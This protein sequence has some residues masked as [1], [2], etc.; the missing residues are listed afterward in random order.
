[1]QRCK[2]PGGRRVPRGAVAVLALALS[3]LAGAPAQALAAAG[4]AFAR[5]VAK[6]DPALDRSV[7]LTVTGALTFTYGDAAVAVPPG[8]SNYT[9][10]GQ[11]RPQTNIRSARVRA[12][13]HRP[14]LQ[15]PAVSI[16]TKGEERLDERTR[17]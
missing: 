17:G 2:S 8:N 3:A 5:E 4:E 10:P 9:G 16:D 7:P 6:C 15:P 11:A 14:A 13:R 1:M 12:S